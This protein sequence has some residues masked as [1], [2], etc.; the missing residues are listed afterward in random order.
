VFTLEEYLEAIELE[1]TID[2]DR[3]LHLDQRLPVQGPKRVRVIVL[4][5]AENEV[6]EAEWLRG[7]AINSAFADM[8]DPAEDIYTMLDGQPIS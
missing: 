4:F 7:A 3:R 1:G 5:P 6:S 2:K 8:N